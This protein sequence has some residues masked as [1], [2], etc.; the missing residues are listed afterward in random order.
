M[1]VWNSRLSVNREGL[2]PSEKHS[3]V[4]NHNHNAC[5]ENALR[6]ADVVTTR[7]GSRLT[8]LR[9]RVLE[10]LWRDHAA[11]KAYD[12]LSLLE[13][14]SGSAKPPTVYRALQF[15]LE[16]GL[17]HRLDTLN[18]YVGCS[19]PSTRH[20]GQF[21]ICTQCDR[22]SE[23]ALEPLNALVKQAASTVEFH[24]HRQSL[25]VLGCC[26]ACFKTCSNDMETQ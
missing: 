3:A 22:V 6:Q 5:V 17:A 1:D 16:N 21:F 18:A 9:R 15:L 26:A 24:V 12:I 10:I 13:E 19:H 14:T 8:D 23:F 4:I 7:N 2:M 11:M 20:I 25:E